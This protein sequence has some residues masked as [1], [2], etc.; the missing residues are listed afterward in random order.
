MPIFETVFIRRCLTVLIGLFGVLVFYL[1]N[2]PVPFLFGPMMACLA[3]SLLR[4]PLVGPGRISVAARTVLGVAVGASITPAVLGQVPSM[5]ASVAIVPIYIAV[6]GLIGVPFFRR[7]CG[8]DPVT[9]FY[10]AMPGGAADMTVFGQEAGANVRQLSLVH[11]T[12]LM[13]I[14]VLVPLILVQFYGTSLRHPVGPPATDLP[15]YE[16]ALMVASAIFGWI[17]AKRLGLFGAPILGPMIVAGLLSVCGILH[18]RPPR[19]ALWAAQFLIGLGIGVSY[20]GVT[21]RELRDTIAGGAAFVVILAVLAAIATETV[22][23]T[24]LA[25]PVEGFLAFA[26][27]GQAE[28]SMLAIIVG[29]DLGFVVV[30]HLTRLVLVILGAPLV[31]RWYL[32][33][34]QRDR[35]GP[36]L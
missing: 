11:V 13:V 12:R 16:L 17:A 28:M 5:L 1:L 15:L 2:L 18:M 24:G 23:L 21:L 9:A 35:G 26:P 14:M 10:A 22:T 32:R 36:D 34:A 25:P 7:V 30:H 6:I 4:M 3:A 27:G 29:A 31:A 8:F 33:R 20:V 19:E